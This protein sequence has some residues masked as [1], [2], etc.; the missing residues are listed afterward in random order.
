MWFVLHEPIPSKSVLVIVGVH[1]EFHLKKYHTSL[2]LQGH[3]VV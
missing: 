1:R 2:G 3:Y